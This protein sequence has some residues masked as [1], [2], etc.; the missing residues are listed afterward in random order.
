M[1]KQKSN[2][3]SILILA[4]IVTGL[5]VGLMLIQNKQIFSPKAAGTTSPACPV[6]AGPGRYV[7]PFNGVVYTSGTAANA[8]VGPVTTSIPTGTYKVTLYSYDVDHTSTNTQVQPNEQWFGILRNSSGGTIVNTATIGDL[9]DKQLWLNQVVNTSL[10]IT[11]PVASVIAKHPMYPNSN[12]NSVN[13]VCAVFE[14]P[15]VSACNFVQI[16]VTQ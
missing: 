4:I 5:I 16:N 3:N 12:P 8:Q 7:V 15:T 14:A 2:K 10:N 6:S 11:Q 1:A 13:P 9:P